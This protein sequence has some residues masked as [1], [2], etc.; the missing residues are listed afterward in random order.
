MCEPRGNPNMLLGVGRRPMG[1]WGLLW[2]GLL[3]WMDS[4]NK[5]Q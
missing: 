5:Q 3:F 4:A 1:L 2:V